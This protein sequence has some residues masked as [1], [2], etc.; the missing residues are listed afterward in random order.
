MKT[1]CTVFCY[2]RFHFTRLYHIPQLLCNSLFVMILF[3]ILTILNSPKIILL[4]YNIIGLLKINYANY[5][6]N[7][8]C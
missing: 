3:S 5:Y 8:V 4:M 2:E 7:S 6:M 1:I